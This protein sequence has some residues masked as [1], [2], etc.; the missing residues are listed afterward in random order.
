MKTSR[1]SSPWFRLLIAVSLALTATTAMAWESRAPVAYQAPNPYWA[2]NNPALALPDNSALPYADR[3]EAFNRLWLQSFHP[4]RIPQEGMQAAGKLLHLWMRNLLTM[5][6]G[7]SHALTDQLVGRLGAAGA[8][9]PRHSR[10]QRGL[11]YRLGA[12]G[13]QIGLAMYY[14]FD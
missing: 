9:Q 1:Q 12:I 5:Q 6:D 14:H 10:R 8:Y 2:A 13:G 3:N 7:N 11:D 4:D